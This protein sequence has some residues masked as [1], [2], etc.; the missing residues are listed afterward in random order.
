MSPKRLDRVAPPP[1]QDEWDIRFG[2]TKAVTGWEDLCGLAETNSR[3]AFE[4][5][6]SNPRPCQDK[7][8][9]RLRG[10]LSTRMF[11]GRELEQWE[12]EVTGGGR[13]FYLVDD[14]EHTV[15]V[16]Y[17]GV[18]HPRQTEGRRRRKR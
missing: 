14:A 13:I 17:A 18:G 11:R 15:W 8:H 12:I 1:V 2:E 10:S 6:R 16:V 9:C 4:L 3:D 7:R 5:M